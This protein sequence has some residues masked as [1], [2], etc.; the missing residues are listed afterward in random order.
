MFPCVAT[1]VKHLYETLIRNDKHHYN[2]Q[3]RVENII[4]VT[5]IISKKLIYNF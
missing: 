2:M 1:E 3:I 4:N 5:Q